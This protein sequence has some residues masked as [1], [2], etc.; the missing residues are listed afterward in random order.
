MFSSHFRAFS[1]NFIFRVFFKLIN[2]L[3]TILIIFSENVFQ[4]ANHL[5]YFI[6][7]FIKHIYANIHMYI[8]YSQY[9]DFFTYDSFFL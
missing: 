5:K 4:C 2:S 7:I 8:L 9:I 6:A 1:I 3:I